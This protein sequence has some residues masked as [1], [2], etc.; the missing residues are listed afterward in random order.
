LVEQ[1]AGKFSLLDSAA[2]P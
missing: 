2:M 1:P